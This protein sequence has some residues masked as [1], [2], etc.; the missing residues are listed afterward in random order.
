MSYKDQVAL[1]IKVLPETLDNNGF[2]LKGGTAIN[3]FYRDM[4]RYSVDI[5]LSPSFIDE[6]QKTIDH[7]DKEF[8]AIS[9]RVQEKYSEIH[10][11]IKKNKDGYAKQI[12]FSEKGAEIKVEVNTILRGYFNSPQILELCNGASNEFNSDASVNCA[13]FEDTYAGKICAGLDRQHPRDLFDI[14]LLLEN[15]GYS[16]QLHKAFLLYLISGNR[17]ISE[18]IEPNR[19]NIGMIYKR[20][21]E[22]MSFI[23]VHLD[24]LHTAR[25]AIIKKTKSQ[26]SD[27]EREFLISL[28]KGEPDWP[29]SGITNIEKF[30][31]VQWKLINIRKMTKERRQK[32]V[33]ELFRKLNM[34]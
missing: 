11:S 28:K 21:F 17:P 14:K 13:S 30:P 8:H 22:G 16:H 31:S 5:D 6:R 34:I 27:Q 25:E 20:Q 24:D 33:N 23:D 15:E 12:L 19:I 9:L 2:C 18:M 4:P 32:A 26:L 7:I 29:L 10:G 1:L 3:L